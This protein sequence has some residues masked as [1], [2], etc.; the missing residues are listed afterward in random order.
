MNDLTATRSTVPSPGYSGQAELTLELAK[1]L[2]L[3]APSSMTSEQQ[4]IWL[5][6]AVDAL[7]DIRGDEVAKVSAEI[8]R[9]ITRHNQ[10]VPAIA[11][12]VAELRKQRAK[13][14]EMQAY[15]ERAAQFPEPL[16]IERKPQTPMT[17][18]E[19]RR[20]P[21]WLRDTGLRV[22]FLKRVGDK[23]VD[24]ETL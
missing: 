17:A 16:P 14:R 23:I 11:E 18:D 13:E 1:M 19:I 12:K 8:R 7:E 24:A 2:A 15:R 9:S 3:V 4:E 5:R 22:G 10:I 21:K 6:A 20:L